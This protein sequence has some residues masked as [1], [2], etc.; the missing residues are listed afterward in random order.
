MVHKRVGGEY[1]TYFVCSVRYINVYTSQQKAA[2][3]IPYCTLRWWYSFLF[4]QL[5]MLVVS[6]F[7]VSDMCTTIE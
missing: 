2:S 1:L 7:T 5:R 3:I 4:V 6:C